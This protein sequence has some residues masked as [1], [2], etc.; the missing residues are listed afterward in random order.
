MI[1]D[2][3]F[4]NPPVDYR[5]QPFWFWNGD[6]EESEILRQIEEMKEK[7]VG[8]FFIC[9]RQG[10]TIS[11]LSRVWFDRVKFAVEAARQAGL[12]VWLYDEYPYPS[13]IAGG[14]VTL[15]HPETVQRMLSRTA[16]E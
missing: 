9:A 4:Q 6:M 12:S 16:Q 11:Y 5:V 3:W 1:N 13:G 10:M 14:E 7:G 8:G 15:E 2:S